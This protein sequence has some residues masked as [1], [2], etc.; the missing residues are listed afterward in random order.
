MAIGHMCKNKIGKWTEVAP[1]KEENY[2]AGG[3]F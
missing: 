3:Y 1:K 2:H